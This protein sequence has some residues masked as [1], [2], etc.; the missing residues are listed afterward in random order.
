MIIVSANEKT[1][2]HLNQHRDDFIKHSQLLKKTEIMNYIKRSHSRISFKGNFWNKQLWNLQ[3]YFI[4]DL[5]WSQKHQ[6]LQSV[7]LGFLNQV[8]FLRIIYPKRFIVHKINWEMICLLNYNIIIKRIL[9]WHCLNRN[10]F[11]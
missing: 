7:S 1:L 6:N 8:N 10:K 5:N 11:Y 2:S 4:V 3:K 9:T